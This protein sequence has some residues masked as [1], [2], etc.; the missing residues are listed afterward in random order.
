MLPNS[1]TSPSLRHVH[2]P[3]HPLWRAPDPAHWS[4]VHTPIGDYSQAPQGAGGL[5]GLRAPGAGDTRPRQKRLNGPWPGA[6]YGVRE[7]EP[8]ETALS[9]AEVHHAVREDLL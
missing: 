1:P 3:L 6:I 5:D 4:I 8:Q 7:P 9:W 2:T